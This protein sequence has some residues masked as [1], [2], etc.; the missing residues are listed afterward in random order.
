MDCPSSNPLKQ[1]VDIET[2][3]VNC[4]GEAA[5]SPE[6]LAE[7]LTDG[8]VYSNWPETNRIGGYLYDLNMC[9]GDV[10]GRPMVF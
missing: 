2:D 9:A 5:A 4:L 3:D 10:R 1:V 6:S 8:L 7:L